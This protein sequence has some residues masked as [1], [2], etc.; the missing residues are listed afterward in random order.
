[1][2]QG[3]WNSMAGYVIIRME[4]PSLERFLNL[5]LHNGIEI[6]NVKRKAASVMTACVGMEGFYALHKLKR[7]QRCRIKILE[8]RGMP[9][10]LT[11]MRFRKLL[12]FGWAVVLAALL[13]A[14]RFV[15]FVQITGCDKI[16]KS[17]IRAILD[18]LNVRAG[19]PR[20]ELEL[21]ELNRAVAAADGRIAWAGARLDGVILYVDIVETGD[22]PHIVK[23][24]PPASIYAARDGVITRIVAYNGR[25]LV[26]VGDAVLK[27]E[28]LISGNMSAEG[29]AQ[30]WVRARG[31]AVA[32]VLYRFTY[33]AGPL[34]DKPVRTG[35]S[36]TYTGLSLFGYRLFE[37]ENVYAESETETLSASTLQNLFLPVLFERH[38][39][40]E[41]INATTEATYEELEAYAVRMAQKALMEGLPKE[42]KMVGK[43]TL[44]NL[45]ESGA[46]QAV[47]DVTM[48]ESIALTIES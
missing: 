32:Q 39:C 24:S 23:T 3:L 47:I 9:V 2:L 21:P 30:H 14:S 37:P 15:W 12:L 34:L 31:E 40:Y 8:K 28:L 43:R 33:T 38:T 44:V 6:W 27:G 36:F 29:Q 46:V 48:E 25:P 19:T 20:G 1:M 18:S 7:S 16:E 4:G 11:R 22:E 42:G 45:L 26:H 41:L 5:A 10:P 35:V 13:G 17:E